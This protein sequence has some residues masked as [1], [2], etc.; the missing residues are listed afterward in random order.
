MSKIINIVIG[1]TV[2]FSTL[3]LAYAFGL[4]AAP[5]SVEDAYR[6]Y[7]TSGFDFRFQL[8]QGDLAKY[9]VGM[10]IDTSQLKYGSN[11]GSLPFREGLLTFLFVTN[12]NSAYATQS[13][14]I[15]FRL[16]SSI[17]KLGLPVR[18]LPAIFS[19]VKPG[20]DTEKYIR[21][22]GFDDYVVWN[23]N[24]DIPET[25]VS[26]PT[27]G[28]LL[29]DSSGIVLRVWFS[30]SSLESVRIRMSDQMIKEVTLISETLN[31]KSFPIPLSNIN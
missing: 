26:M 27:P 17:E 7:Y 31:L 5:S 1:V 8:E 21:T 30:S 9:K 18:H 22:L 20:T 12:P 23:A 2:A 29:M 15:N 28:F 19:S 14:D 24:T 16:K 10:R 11:R 13:S 25:L 3:I 6:P 4:L